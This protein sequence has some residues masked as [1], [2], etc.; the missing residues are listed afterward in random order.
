M[1]AYFLLFAP[2]FQDDS[3]T[4]IN[5]SPLLIFVQFVAAIAGSK[6]DTDE[7]G[8]AVPWG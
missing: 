4:L 6:A 8:V 5:F 3:L 1:S 7:K 2:V